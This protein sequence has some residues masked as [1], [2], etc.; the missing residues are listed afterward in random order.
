MTTNS[1]TIIVSE[2]RGDDGKPVSMRSSKLDDRVISLGIFGTVQRVKLDMVDDMM[3][4]GRDKR[5]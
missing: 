5:S 1:S 4:R 2:R 3:L